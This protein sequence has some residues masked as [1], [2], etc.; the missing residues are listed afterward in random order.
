VPEAN[1]DEEEDKAADSEDGGDKKNPGDVDV[2]LEEASKVLRDAIELKSGK[3]SEAH[4][5][6]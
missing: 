2:V 4:K 1:E 5:A 6:P 3:L